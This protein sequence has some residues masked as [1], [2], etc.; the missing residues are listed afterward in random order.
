MDANYFRDLFAYNFWANRKVWACLEQISDEQFRQ[1]TGYSF[2]ALYWQTLHILIVEWWWFRFLQEGV[3]DFPNPDDLPT[4]E[5]IRAKW[6]ETEAYVMAYLA[7]LTPAELARAV[8]P[9]FW[10]QQGPIKVWQAIY[11]VALH[12]ND[13]RAQILA[14]LHQLGAPTVEQDYLGYLAEQEKHS[15]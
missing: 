3:L 1:E 5:L 7:A 10:E 13:H 11:Q 15:K 9:E 14:T 4:R 2:G 8:R 12:S 6:D